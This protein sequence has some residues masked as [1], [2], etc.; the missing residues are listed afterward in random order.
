VLFDSPADQARFIRERLP[1]EGLF[2]GLD[3]RIS[4]RPFGL[5]AEFVKE[6][7]FLGRILLQFNRAANLLYRLSVSGKQPAWVSEWLDKGKPAALIELQR[8]AIFKNDLP[9][10]IR[11]DLL[12]TE[13]RAAITELDSI[14][15][16]IGLTGWLN[17]KY[18]ELN[19]SRPSNPESAG[20]SVSATPD[21]ML[22]I[23]RIESWVAPTE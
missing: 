17:Q 6:L 3:F 10:V 8:S 16:G 21:A 22:P 1:K 4:P 2:G 19:G 12:L 14:P 11:P 20:D 18:S 9:R 13:T 7:E 5:K 23:R 15:G